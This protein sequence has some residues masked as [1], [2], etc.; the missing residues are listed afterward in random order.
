MVFFYQMVQAIQSHVNMQLIALK[1]LLK[2]KIP[3]FGICLGHQL[4]ALASGA[5]TEKMKFGHHGANHPVRDLE[6]GKFL[7]QAKIMDSP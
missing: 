1:A 5:E 6:S 7:S 4:L 2:K 3:I